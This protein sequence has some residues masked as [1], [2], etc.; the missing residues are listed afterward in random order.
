MQNIHT[1]T[2]AYLRV[3]ENDAIILLFADCWIHVDCVHL[4][5]LYIWFNRAKYFIIIF[6]LE[7][8]QNRLQVSIVFV[9]PIVGAQEII[10]DFSLFLIINYWTLI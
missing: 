4:T 6:M 5:V 9:C 8:Y 7:T 1:H 2:H 10:Y 3:Y